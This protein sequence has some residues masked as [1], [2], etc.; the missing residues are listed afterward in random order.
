VDLVGMLALLCV[1]V[2]RLL[3]VQFSV[4][5]VGT[6]HLVVWRFEFHQPIVWSVKCFLAGFRS[7]EFVSV[8][9]GCSS[10]V[11]L[12]SHYPPIR[13]ALKP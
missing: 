13:G 7:W 1:F 3:S 9:V 5:L 10:A 2:Q 11:A 6:N 12:L 4:C 8:L